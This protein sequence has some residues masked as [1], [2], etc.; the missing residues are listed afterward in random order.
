MYLNLRRGCSS[1]APSTSLLSPLTLLLLLLLLLL[2]FW[3]WV[4]G[5]HLKS[6]RWAPLLPLLV[7]L[8]LLLLLFWLWIWW[9]WLLLLWL[10]LL[11]LVEGATWT[12]FFLHFLTGPVNTVAGPYRVEVR[13]SRAPTPSMTHCSPNRPP[14]PPKIKNYFSLS[15]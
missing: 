7:P 3:L 14:I 6:K 1:G 8:L 5:V 9:E 11:L 4:I 10:L 15:L 13:P 2:L 12:H